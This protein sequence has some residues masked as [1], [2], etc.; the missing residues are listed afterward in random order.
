MEELLTKHKWFWAWQDDLE[1]AWLTRMAGEGWHLVTVS[2]FGFYTFQPGPGQEVVYRLD[3]RSQTR[4]QDRL[5]YLQLFADAGWEHVAEMGGWQYF[6][7]PVLPGE[8][9]ELYTDVE[10]KVQKYNRLIVLL[11]VFLPIILQLSARMG[12]AAAESDWYAI[13]LFLVFI[14]LLIYIYAMIQL[15]KRIN[16][17]KKTRELKQ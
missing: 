15:I 6:R 11:V 7:K 14:L 3:Y 12:D 9:P 4:K 1:E 10:S 17:L 13:P 16:Q 2:P 5:D 8:E